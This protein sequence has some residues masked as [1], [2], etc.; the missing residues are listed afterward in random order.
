[1]TRAREVPK[2]ATTSVLRQRGTFRLQDALF[3]DAETCVRD[4]DDQAQA[5]TLL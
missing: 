3:T 5:P 4:L 2:G 1:V